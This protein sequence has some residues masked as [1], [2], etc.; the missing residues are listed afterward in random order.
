[1]S[2]LFNT[3]LYQEKSSARTGIV[4]VYMCVWLSV[5]ICLI[6]IVVQLLVYIYTQ[7]KKKVNTYSTL[8]ISYTN[9]IDGKCHISYER[10][11]P[12]L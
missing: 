4:H 2:V 10:E 5:C 7:H 6:I 12:P 8:I 11:I 3:F 9:S 1:M